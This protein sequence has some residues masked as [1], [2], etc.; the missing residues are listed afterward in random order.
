MKVKAPGSHP[1][2][3]GKRDL[4]VAEAAGRCGTYEWRRSIALLRAALLTAA[5]CAPG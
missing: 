4:G 1:A 3:C 2:R 5:T